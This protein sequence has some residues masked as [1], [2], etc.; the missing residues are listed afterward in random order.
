M[1]LMLKLGAALLIFGQFCFKFVE[2]FV[3]YLHNPSREEW[4][5]VMGHCLCA[6]HGTN[7]LAHR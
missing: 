6:T 3:F 2:F 7:A 1:I 4:P 5:N